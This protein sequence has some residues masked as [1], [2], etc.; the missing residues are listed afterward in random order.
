M[1]I[2]TCV[3]IVICSNILHMQTNSVQLSLPTDSFVK[4]SE[5]DDVTVELSIVDT[6]SS[7]INGIRP[8]VS[9]Q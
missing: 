9:K 8:E 2:A 3:C 4:I 7:S 5:S 6:V 1:N